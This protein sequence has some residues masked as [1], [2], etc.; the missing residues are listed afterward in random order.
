MD[1]YL[2]ILNIALFQC[3]TG[4]NP[5][6]VFRLTL[7][8]PVTEVVLNEHQRNL[9]IRIRYHFD[10]YIKGAQNCQ[11]HS[12]L[13]DIIFSFGYSSI[14]VYLIRICTQVS[15]NRD[16]R[17]NAR[18]RSKKNRIMGTISFYIKYDNLLFDEIE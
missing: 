15:M 13:C 3:Y 1:L 9:V 16:N 17:T 6:F 12:L 14:G 7:R 8:N 2:K 18:L 4:L 5:I 11:M 10:N